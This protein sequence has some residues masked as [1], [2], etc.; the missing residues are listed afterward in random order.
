M[1]C[2]SV[3]WVAGCTIPTKPDATRMPL[4][5]VV[6]EEFVAD[7]LP[8]HCAEWNA[9]R[10]F[11]THT[12]YTQLRLDLLCCTL[13]FAAHPYAG[14]AFGSQMMVHTW[15][16]CVKAWQHIRNVWTGRGRCILLD[17]WRSTVG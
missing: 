5:P 12:I 8:A 15:L 13:Y 4:R 11:D 16:L 17:P 10:V 6:E 14:I 9:V 7:G 1:I 2:A 3:Q